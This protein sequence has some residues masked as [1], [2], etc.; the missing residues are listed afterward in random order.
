[1]RPSLLCI[2]RDPDEE[3]EAA[4]DVG[5]AG[6]SV[7]KYLSKKYPDLK[8]K[9]VGRARVG[10]QHEQYLVAMK[11]KLVRKR[12][13]KRNFKRLHKIV[14]EDPVITGHGGK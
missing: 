1:L 12:D 14:V 13:D 10:G 4:I 2:R 6:I 5:E 11:D 8:Q 7:K 9:W 3:G